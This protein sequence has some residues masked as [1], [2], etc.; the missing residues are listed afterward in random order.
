MY[1]KPHLTSHSDCLLIHIV[2]EKATRLLEALKGAGFE[3]RRVEGTFGYEDLNTNNGREE[4]AS[5]KL[6]SS[7]DKLDVR[8]FLRS[9][10]A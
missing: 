3:A 8:K 7:S 9:W 5:I 10:N 6:P 1:D 2:Q 4:V